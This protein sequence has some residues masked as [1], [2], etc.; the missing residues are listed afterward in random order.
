LTLLK[1]HPTDPQHQEASHPSEISMKNEVIRKS[2]HLSSIGIPLIY[3]L[4]GRDVL[5][6][7]LVPATIISVVVEFIR[8]RVPTV[9]AKLRRVFGTIMRQHELAE[10]H[11]KISGATWVL[12]S[13][14]FC[15]I[16]FPQLIAMAGFTILIVSDTAAAL[17]GRKFGRHRFLE[18]SVEGSSAFYVTAMMVVGALMLIYDVPMVFLTTG[19]AAAFAATAAEAFSYGANID[20][21]LTI[22]TSYGLV[23]WGLLTLHGGPEVERIWEIGRSMF[24]G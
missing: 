11:A 22:P 9:E 4:A 12:L 8:M 17:F 10:A 3:G 19:A 16:V 6:W 15:V 2:I 14:T 23:Q 20:D 1:Q 5:L 18:K 13:A 21:N 24:F 7:L